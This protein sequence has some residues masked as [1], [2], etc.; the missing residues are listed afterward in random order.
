MNLFISLLVS[1]VAV[2]VANPIV[3][4]T[5][6]DAEL[7][8]RTCQIFG[9]ICT[10]PASTDACEALDGWHCQGKGLPPIISD[11]TCAANCVCPC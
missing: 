4:V 9:M 6:R 11:P 8:A 5:A 3:D 10:A 1:F 7:D 2:A